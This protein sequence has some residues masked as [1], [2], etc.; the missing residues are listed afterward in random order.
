MPSCSTVSFP[1]PSIPIH[2]DEYAALPDVQVAVGTVQSP[3]T[4]VKVPPV[5]T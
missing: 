3:L 2:V 4:E 1:S 5:S